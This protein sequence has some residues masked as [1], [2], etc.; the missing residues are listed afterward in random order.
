MAVLTDK[1]PAVTSTTIRIL[2]SLIMSFFV[3]AFLTVFQPF[4]L[5]AEPN[6][7]MFCAGYGLTCFIV[8]FVLNVVLVPLLPGFFNEKNWLVWKEIVWVVINVSFIGL[9]NALY[10]AWILELEFTLEVVGTFQ[11]YTVAVA[12]LPIIL[13]VLTNYSRLRSKYERFSDKLS[14]DI[15]GHSSN[16]QEISL[17]SGNEALALNTESFLFAKSADNYLEFVYQDGD[18]LKREVIRKTLKS[19]TD[20][21]EEYEHIFQV[22]R[23]YLVNLERVSRFSGN[24]QGLKLHFEETD[25]IVPVSRNLTNALKERLT[26]RH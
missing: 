19:A 3:L 24:A 6:A 26:I 21:L 17:S 4:G 7:I 13:S 18:L 2:M 10:S 22:H 14:K 9:A 16:V 5:N 1:Y 12:L 25:S 11:F 20:E 8:M 15:V 23:S